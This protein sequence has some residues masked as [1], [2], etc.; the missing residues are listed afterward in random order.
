VRRLV[1]VRHGQTEWSA[2]GRH[3]GR[4]DIPL[5]PEGEAQARLLGQLLAGLG[6]VP[7][8]SLSS[9]LARARNTAELAGLG[10]HLELSDAL[11]EMDYGEDEGL[12]I[13][14]IRA[15]RPGW[16]L[17][18]DGCPGGETVEAVA[19]RVAPLIDE[20]SPEAGDG[21]VVVVAHGHV[22][23]VLA[24]VYLAQPPA[25]ARALALA[26]A[27][28]SILGHEHEWRSVQLW[29]SGA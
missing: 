21:D 13:S 9:P 28:V 2:T 23:R 24:A 18:R 27:T 16:D 7:T 15:R 6:V 1:L 14:E 12:A 19:R 22:L 29:N 11:L 26:T 5:L 17:F 3:T 4:T 8:R 20:L 25:F 10:D